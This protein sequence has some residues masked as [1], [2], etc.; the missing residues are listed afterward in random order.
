MRPLP[1][2]VSVPA[3]LPALVRTNAAPLLAAA[4]SAAAF[5]AL[6]LAAPRR[7][8]KLRNAKGAGINFPP[9]TF[10]REFLKSYR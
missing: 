3:P 5:A 6:I 2:R 9:I 1:P 4:N 7:S 10:M 8:E